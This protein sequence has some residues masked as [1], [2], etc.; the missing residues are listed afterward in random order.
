[1]PDDTAFMPPYKIPRCHI[2]KKL[3]RP[4]GLLNSAVKHDEIMQQLHKP[5][6]SAQGNQVFIQTQRIFFDSS[7]YRYG[8]I[9][10]GVGIFFPGKVILFRCADGAIAEPLRI[11]TGQ[12]KP[13]GS[14]KL[15]NHIRALVC[16]VLADSLRH[17]DRAALQFN[18]RKGDTVDIQ[19][20]VRAFVFDS[21]FFCNVKVIFQRM[22]PIHKLD[23]SFM[24]A[25]RLTDLDPVAQLFV[26][27][28][29]QVV[30]IH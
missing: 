14:E 1:M 29:V 5:L 20:Q 19:H 10:F 23:S 13:Y 15:H 2:A 17:G 8:Y 27:L 25:D 26:C 6:F 28:F 12:N 16:Q 7:A 30:K 24:L 3:I 18:D 4:T 9:I 21:D 11:I 22:R